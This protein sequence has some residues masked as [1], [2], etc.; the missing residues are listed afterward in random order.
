[1]FC[2]VSF[3]QACSGAAD[4]ASCTSRWPI[5]APRTCASTGAAPWPAGEQPEPAGSAAWRGP[6]G[7]EHLAR[8]MDPKVRTSGPD[9]ALCHFVTIDVR[10]LEEEGVKAERVA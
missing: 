4:M 6:Q 8:P 5:S 7:R 10:K 1:M 2:L 3:T 9:P